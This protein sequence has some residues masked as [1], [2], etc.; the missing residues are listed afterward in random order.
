MK[1]T[2]KRTLVALALASLAGPALAGPREQA[3]RL[4]S[5]LAGVPPSPEVLAQME[6]LLSQ[7]NGGAAAQLAMESPSFYSV[8]LK[9]WASPWTNQDLTVR[10]P[11]NDYTATVIGMARD[12]VPFDQILYGDILYTGGTT[13]GVPA[14]SPASNDHYAALEAQAVDLK[15]ALVKNQQTVLNPTVTEV[16]G[17]MTTR[18]FGEAYYEAGTNRAA[19]RFSFMTFLCNDMEQMSDT[20]IPDFRV[21]RDVDRQPG[22]DAKVYRNKCAGCH[23]GMDG[24]GGAFAHFDWDGTQVTYSP[25]VVVAKY[26]QNAST[27]PDG[28]VTTDDGWINMWTE[29]QNARIGWDGAKTGNGAQQY[30]QMLAAT[31]SFPRCMAKRVYSSVCLQDIKTITDDLVAPFADAFKSDGFNLKNLFAAAAL[32]CMGE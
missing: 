10:V 12:N 30:G 31:D 21:R 29:G 26:A 5:R 23:A 25:D 20:S 11:L 4:H 22:G 24:F 2:T 15:A 28:Y 6:T 3:F 32:Q 7:G 1:S 19:V 16:A 8:T 14:Y 18:A 9:D 17:A 13:A 27:F